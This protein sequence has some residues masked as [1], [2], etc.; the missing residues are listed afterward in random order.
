MSITEVKEP[1]YLL[2]M[3]QYIAVNK[4]VEVEK[5]AVE[6]KEEAVEDEEENM[7][8]DWGYSRRHFTSTKK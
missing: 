1:L 7:S 6:D 4:E 5:E 2:Y 8:W 3:G